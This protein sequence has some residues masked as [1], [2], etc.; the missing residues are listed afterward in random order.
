MSNY[1]CQ[2]GCSQLYP[3]GE[4]HNHEILGSTFLVQCGCETH[5]HRFAGVSGAAIPAPNNH[6]K[7]NIKVCTDTYDGHSHEITAVSGTEIF[8]GDNRHIHFVKDQTETSD[9]H[10]HCFRASSLIENPIENRCCD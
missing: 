10:E 2:S 7:H 4:T 3:Q 6:H 1:E 5:N 8:V 9:G